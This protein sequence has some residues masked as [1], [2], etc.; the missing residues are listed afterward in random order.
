MIM[1]YKNASSIYIYITIY[2]YIYTYIYIYIYIYLMIHALLY[3]EIKY[4]HC[5]LMQTMKITWNYGWYTVG[6]T[7][8]S[9]H[10]STVK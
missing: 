3:H 8:G 4:N 1:A 2:I 9:G 10:N 6:Q 5:F 7:N